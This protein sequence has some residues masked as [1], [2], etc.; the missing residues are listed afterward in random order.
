MCPGDRLAALR[1]SFCVVTAAFMCS[2]AELEEAWAV[3]LRDLPAAESSF[4]ADAA[5]I[6]AGWRPLVE[7]ASSF[8]DRIA[9]RDRIRR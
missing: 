5:M 2:A 1:E 9:Q 6:R 7:A 4:H 3:A 8:R